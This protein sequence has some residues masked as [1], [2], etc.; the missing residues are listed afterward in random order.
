MSSKNIDWRNYKG[1]TT[2]ATHMFMGS[3]SWEKKLFLDPFKGWKNEKR[4]SLQIMKWICWR[5]SGH[6]S[7]RVVPLGGP[8]APV[9]TVCGLG[10]DSR[11]GVPWAEPNG[12]RVVA[13]RFTR[14]QDGGVHQ[15]HLDLVFSPGRDLSRRRDPTI[16]LGISQSPKISLDDIESQIGED[17]DEVGYVTGYS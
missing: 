17:W 5:G 14:A 11:S 9:Q 10:L 4:F 2:I 6:K 15:W 7:L 13:R 1:R 12:P 16:F 3:G 8:S